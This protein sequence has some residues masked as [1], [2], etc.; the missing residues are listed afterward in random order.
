M[1]S[2]AQY[3]PDVI[4][5]AAASQLGIFALM[6]LAV[7]V[8]GYLFFKGASELVRLA[9]FVL[10]FAGVAA[11]GLAIVRESDEPVRDG[12][13]ATRE[14]PLRVVSTSSPTPNR[15]SMPCDQREPCSPDGKW[16]AALTEL[17]VRAGEGEELRNARIS[18]DGNSCGWRKDLYPEY[19]DDKRVVVGKVLTWSKPVVLRL[20]AEAW[21]VR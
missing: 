3:V 4:R 6:V 16:F 19:S 1:E 20:E 18:C 8:I 15:D 5:A 21:R 10:M 7:A 11:F 12:G 17:T 13:N 9:I 2:A 14:T